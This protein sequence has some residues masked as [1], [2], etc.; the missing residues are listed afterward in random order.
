MIV[1]NDVSRPDSGFAVD[2]N[3]VT[4]IFASGRRS[5]LPL[6]TKAE[7]AARIVAEIAANP[8]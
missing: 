3:R 5:Y 6:L 2:T 4:F 7:V 8:H 1:A